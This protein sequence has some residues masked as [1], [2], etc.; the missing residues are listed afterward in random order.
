MRYLLVLL[1]VLACPIGCGSDGSE[2]EPCLDAIGDVSDEYDATTEVL[3][4]DCSEEETDAL[5]SLGISWFW[6]GT[7]PT[8]E[9][10]PD[11]TECERAISVADDDCVADG[12]RTCARP[13]GT[14]WRVQG[15]ARQSGPD[16][17][18]VHAA[19]DVTVTPPAGQS[20]GG[21][22]SSVEIT[23]VRR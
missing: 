20:D 14:T 3:S 16:G 18:G 21:C 19:F 7:G 22:T 23:Y 6:R 12:E 15:V 10:G 9:V 8:V 11:G 4:G 17:A 13:D 5:S 1:P 2:D